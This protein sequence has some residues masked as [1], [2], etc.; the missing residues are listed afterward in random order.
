MTT[1]HHN[2]VFFD[3]EDRRYVVYTFEKSSNQKY[4]NKLQNI[5]EDKYT[6]YQF[7]KFLEEH[8][9]AHKRTNEWIKARPLTEDYFAMRSED[10]VDQ[11]LRDFV[12]LESIEVDHLDIKDYYCD[13]LA[14]ND[15]DCV[16]VVKDVLYRK[17]KI[18]CHLIIVISPVL[19]TE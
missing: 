8:K 19:L 11:F 12:K 9:I 14:A 1:N 10:T 13:D 3:D 18:K 7:V 17:L 2:G 15:K 6:I 4:I 5:M 16:L